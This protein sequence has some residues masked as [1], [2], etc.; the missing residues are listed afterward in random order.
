LTGLNVF[1]NRVTSSTSFFSGFNNNEVFLAF[2][3]DASLRGT[4]KTICST[5]LACVV[6]VVEFLRTLDQSDT[7]LGYWVDKRVVRT[8]ATTSCLV[9]NVSIQAGSAVSWEAGD[10]LGS[11]LQL[12]VSGCEG[13]VGAGSAVFRA[14]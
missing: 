2:C 14:I 12:D 9:G 5:R 3:A 1:E 6:Q 13:S 4:L 11:W 10:W 8:C 7:S